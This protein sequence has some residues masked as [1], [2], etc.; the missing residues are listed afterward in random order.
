MNL[1]LLPTL[2]AAALLGGAAVAAPQGSVIDTRHNLSATGPGPIR[3]PDEKEVCIFCHAAHPPESGPT[4]WNHLSSPVINY[5]PYERETMKAAAGRVDGSSILCLSCH[6]GTI[7]LGA[8][9][10]RP[11][12]IRVAGVDGGG[13]LSRERASN[14]GTDLSGTHPV[15]I[16][17]EEALA[18]PEPSAVR[19]RDLSPDEE[20][21]WL[22]SSGKVQCTSCH[23]P[24]V[25]PSTAGAHVPP[26][27]RGD[28]VAEVCE[29]CH[30]APLVDAPHADPRLLANGCGSCHVGHGVS[31]EALLAEREEKACYACHATEPARAATAE[32][33]LTPLARPSAIEPLFDLPYRHPVDTSVGLHTTGEDLATEGA[34]APRHVECV[35]CHAQHGEE[36]PA[37]RGRENAS[38]TLGG[39]P[40][41]EVC[42]SCH[43][44][45]S[46][47][48]YGQTDKSVEFDAN[49]RSFHPVESPS[50]SSSVPSL[51]SPWREGRTMTCSDCHTTD[52]A[53]RPQGP[54]GSRFPWILSAA[55]TAVDGEPES[56]RAYE[57]C[58]SCHSRGTILS[59]QTFAGHSQH[60]VTGRTSCYGCH[61]SHGSPD[62]PGLVRFGKDIRYTDVRPSKSGRLE[63]DE[64]TGE[65]WLTCHD[66]DHD[67]LGYGP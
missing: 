17:Y 60:V 38:G 9:H 26:F 61:D 47:L 36:A 39:R 40:E 46:N 8:V 65:C 14:L 28:T 12:T 21:T 55:Y 10:S 62:D 64:S 57:L 50:P 7:A 42:Y 66:V 30:V 15:S 1:R 2:L 18:S 3:A 25:D 19:V 67:P 44:T 63:Y 43:G 4:L 23:D 6:D 45:V 35:D 52:D 16:V 41:Y 53:R 59:D 20:R 56:V 11:D 22:D 33:R 31:G 34:A 29:T 5:R 54:H 51:L 49:N 37:S 27:W 13:R 58:Y 24:H 32:G 48:P